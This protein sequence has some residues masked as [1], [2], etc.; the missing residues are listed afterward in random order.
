ME[1]AHACEELPKIEP[2]RAVTKPSAVKKKAIPRKKK[3][4]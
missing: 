4:V 3:G 2:R 1:N